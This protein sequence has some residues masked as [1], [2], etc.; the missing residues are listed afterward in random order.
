[1]ASGSFHRSKDRGH[2]TSFNS[3]EAGLKRYRDLGGKRAMISSVMVDLTAPESHLA[4]GEPFNLR[5][6]PE[7]A[8]E[9]LGKLADMGYDD[10]LL[11]KAEPGRMLY[12]A[13]LD[14]EYLTL[15]RSLLPKH[16]AVAV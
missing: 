6:G 3:L 16:E 10:V 8:A 7:S 12:E 15:L 14:E 11:V 1:M 4:D 2:E 13:D 9:R 5:C